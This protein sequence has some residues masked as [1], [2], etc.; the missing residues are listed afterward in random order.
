MKLG[1]YITLDVV[2]SR[3]GAVP[4]H[5]GSGRAQQE[6]IYRTFTAPWLGDKCGDSIG[7]VGAAETA[8]ATPPTRC[9]GGTCWTVSNT[10][11]ILASD[12]GAIPASQPR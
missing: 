12:M 11:S 7:G 1:Y 10:G 6:E 4:I 5:G 3:K 8:T 2:V 9:T